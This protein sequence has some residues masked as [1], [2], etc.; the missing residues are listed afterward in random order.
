MTFELSE[1]PPV[2][3]EV[4]VKLADYAREGQIFSPEA[5]RTARWCL[6]DAL[7][8]GLQ[9]LEYPACTRLLGPL[10]PGTVVPNGARVP[11]TQYILDPVTAAFDIGAL[12]RWLDF[13]DTWLAAEWGHPSDNLAGILASADWYSR[14]AR[15]AGKSVLSMRQVLNALIKA[16]E[17]QGA[18]ALENSFNRVGLDHVLLVK[19]ATAAVV[20]ALL[21]GTRE[22]VIN[23]VSNAWAD[24]GTL[25]VYRQAPNAGSRKSWAAGDAAS[26]GVRLALLALQGEM[27]YPTALTAPIWGFQD[28]L[29][30]GHALSLSRGLESYVIENILFKVAFPAE[31]HGQTAVEAAIL[32]HPQA[33]AR[34]EQ[35]ERIVIATQESAM[36]IINKGGP[37]TNPS[38]RDHCLQY[39][40]AVALIHGRLR[41]EDYLDAAA[42]DPRID[43]L[44]AVMDVREEPGFSRDYLDPEKRSIAN[45][46]QIFY[47]DGSQS[48][49]ITVEYPLG[50]R[51]RRAEGIPLLEEKFKAALAGRFSQAQAAK[52]LH[53]CQDQALLESTPVDEFMGLWVPAKD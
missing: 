17:I 30:N 14:N 22:Q 50:H 5:Y 7:G 11:G 3:D 19:V 41:A 10:A 27:G 8:C 29:M 45:A 24:G 36:R 21:G 37:L 49:K 23:A 9:A 51:R 26:R 18:L 2:V 43:A 6:M 1:Q 40:T 32:L 35:I 44:R 33:A 12:N 39:M 28:A 46:L 16:Y 48:E 13:N 4:L 15:A 47:K 20:T 42:L 31:F 53:L 25:R 34:L 38:D 52:I